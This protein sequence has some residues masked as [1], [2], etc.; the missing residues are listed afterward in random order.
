MHTFRDEVITD[1]LHLVTVDAMLIQLLRLSQYA[2]H[3]ID[4]HYNDIRIQLFQSP[5]DTSDSAASAS[6]D[7][8]HVYVATRLLPNICTQS[9]TKTII[10]NK[11][12]ITEY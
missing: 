7:H 10:H 11:Q 5:T 2:A 9:T 4:A 1:A 8:H 12:I 6:C 3:W